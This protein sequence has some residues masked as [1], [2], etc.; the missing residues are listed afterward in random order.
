VGEELRRGRRF[1]PPAGAAENRPPARLRE[2]YV[3]LP[4]S[5]LPNVEPWPSTEK[6]RVLR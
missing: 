5:R 2:S 1:R 4:A 6:I 3:S